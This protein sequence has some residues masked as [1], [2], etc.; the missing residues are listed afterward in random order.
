M[1]DDIV[2]RIAASVKGST[3]VI[4][5]LNIMLVGRN[6]AANISKTYALGLAFASDSD[7]IGPD[8]LNGKAG[9]IICPVF[10]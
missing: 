10:W 8:F 3:V 2:Q 9:K 6:S 1:A 4:A 5:L 7:E